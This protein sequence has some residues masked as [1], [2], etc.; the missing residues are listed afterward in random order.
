[1]FDYSWRC[2]CDKEGTANTLAEARK[3]V[4]AH[5]RNHYDRTPNW[6]AFIDQHEKGGD[7]TDKSWKQIKN[8]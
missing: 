1:M 4:R 7:L 3:E 6:Y 2:E 8:H 5:L